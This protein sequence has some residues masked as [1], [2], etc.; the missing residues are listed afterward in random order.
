MRGGEGA[1]AEMLEKEEWERE[2]VRQRKQ[3]R[4][5]LQ[6][7]SG[8]RGVSEC[9]PPLFSRVKTPG[10]LSAPGSVIYH[11]SGEAGPPLWPM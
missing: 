6:C 8:Q 5:R 7:V 1:I 2:R 3:T 9:S 11:Q 10:G 4:Q